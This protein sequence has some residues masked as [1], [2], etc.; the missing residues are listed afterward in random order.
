MAKSADQKIK[1]EQEKRAQ[2]SMESN[3]M[4]AAGDFNFDKAFNAV[5]GD[6]GKDASDEEKAQQLAIQGN[7]VQSA[8]DAQ[9]AQGLA[10]TNAEIS[11][12]LMDKTSQLELANTTEIMAQEQ[13]Y[14]LA[15]M[16]A[17]AQIQDT[18]ANNEFERAEL[19][20]ASQNVRDQANMD[21]QNKLD[22]SR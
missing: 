7:M 20:A 17:Q 2:D 10:Y 12:Q 9:T 8:I 22:I 5:M 14:G 19:A 13:Q 16:A 18:F 11:A 3:S 6:L 1:E 21:L 4:S 15:Q